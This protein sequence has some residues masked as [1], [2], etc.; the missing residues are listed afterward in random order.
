MNIRKKM[1]GFDVAFNISYLYSHQISDPT[2]IH[3]VSIK[4]K[5]NFY[6]KS[7]KLGLRVDA[8]INR[9]DFF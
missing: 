6:T 2:Q 1:P 9:S 5:M 7:V 4:M 8:N 3:V